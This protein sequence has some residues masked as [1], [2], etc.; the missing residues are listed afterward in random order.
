MG[1][2]SVIAKAYADEPVQLSA[3]E[4]HDKYVI[5]A[6]EDLSKTIGF[7]RDLVF[8][9][10]ADLYERLRKAY[11]QGSHEALTRLWNEAKP[12]NR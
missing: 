5:V 10:D 3:L 9:F 4:I 6:G 2:D 1:I 11:G 8:Q 12:M 7:P